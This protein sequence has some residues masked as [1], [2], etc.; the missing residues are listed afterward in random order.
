MGLI[1][2]DFDLSQAIQL[3]WINHYNSWLILY[4]YLASSYFLYIS[5]EIKIPYLKG[6]RASLIGLI[7]FL[8]AF[9]V[10]FLY[11]SVKW[12]NHGFVIE[13]WQGSSGNPQLWA[14]Q[15]SL[16]LIVWI[17]IHGDLDNLFKSKNYSRLIISLLITATILTGSISNFIGLGFASL[18]WLV[19]WAWVSLF[20]TLAYVI[21]V[22]L[23]TWNFLVNYQGDILDLKN[24]FQGLSNKFIPRL[25]LWLELLKESS[26]LH[27]DY[28]SGIGL[29]AYNDFLDKATLSKH[30]NVHSLY[31]HN[32]L[33]NGIAGVYITFIF[34][35]SAL[36]KI[37]QNKYYL[38]ICLYVLS[39]SVFDCALNF[40]EIQIVFW[41]ILP[42]IVDRVEPMKS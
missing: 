35:T 41:L 34:L 30:E 6:F 27:L 15:A 26:N 25:K 3:Q 14:V 7:I 19:P 11:S 32:W 13:R 8:L 31:L 18:A 22:N 36:Q 12:F 5:R 10:D 21:V 17:I 40:L 20:I 29:N 33:I 16:M 37:L 28:L 23:W 42:L 24:I 9:A 1:H 4:A 2:G 39:S 38:A